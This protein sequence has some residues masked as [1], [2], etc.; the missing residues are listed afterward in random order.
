MA[1]NRLA[2][3]CAVA[4]FTASPLLAQTS[5]FLPDELFEKLVNEISGDRSYENVRHLSLY[6]RTEG[7][8]D[9]FKANEW[10]VSAAKEAGLEDVKLIR[11]KN[12]TPGWTCRKGE[13]WL[14]SGPDAKVETKLAAYGEVA[15]S[16]ADNSRTTH[17]TADL[18][19]VGWGVEESDYK[20]KDVKGKVVF[21]GGPLRKVNAEAVWRR[22]ALGV[23]SY[24]TH[25]P[26][27][28]DAPDQVA[29]T[30]LPYEARDVA[31][32]KDKT[33]PTFA[34]VISPRRA[35]RVQKTLVEGAAKI[36]VDIDAEFQPVPEQALVEGWIRGTENHD[37]QIVLT[38]HTQEG[39]GAN[40]DASG[41]G[42]V[43]EIGRALSRLIKDGKIPR[44]KRDIRFWW[45]NEFGSQER[46]FREDPGQAK[47]MLV[48]LNQDMV[49][50][51]QSLGG[52]VEYGSRLP[53]SIPHVL[54]D[55]MESVLLFM[56]DANTSLL[57][58]RGTKHRQPFT[59]EVVSVKGSREP[60]HARMVPYYDSTDH[61]AF[62]PAHIGVPATSLTNWPDDF[63]H[64]TGDDIDQ[65]DATQ[66]ERN[67]VVTAGVALYF[68]NVSKGDLPLLASY[69]AARGAVRLADD[70][71]TAITLAAGG[72]TTASY[73]AGRGLITNRAARESASLVSVSRL[74]AAPDPALQAILDAGS[75]ALDRAQNT[76]LGRL[77]L[78]AHP[79]GAGAAATKTERALS[80]EE[81][82]LASRIYG[83]GRSVAEIQD[84][85]E[86]MRSDDK[87]PL[88]PMM[89]F[90]VINFADGKRSGLE[91]YD[92]V[93]A[94]AASAGEWYYGKVTAAD[95]KAFLDGAVKAGVCTER[96][97][98]R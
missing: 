91:V 31:G 92:A 16:I 70:A 87:S 47:K 73:Q 78:I 97:A 71:A 59:R 3:V 79:A 64:S 43:L 65:I 52:R 72:K 9:Y 45:V 24:E 57:T 60:Y 10:I 95:V 54:E 98:G 21:A 30:R 27:A 33:P 93:A 41:C 56:R 46:L 83:P 13:A 36:R 2:L 74:A 86:K 94:E 69:A 35:R 40:D 29:W 32:V 51:R 22:G 14:M 58:T 11:Q 20:D 7:S 82:H 38:A 6:H 96:E 66:L 76:H 84:G 15:V 85:L 63:I 12:N 17:L 4:G 5:P 44:P 28:F 53:W 8:A 61:H 39:A 25:R 68:A 67:A 62:T 50:A 80:A 23:L 48:A 26:E 88:H 89:R 75:A 49:G 37:Q 77:D 18:V 34:V 1:L 42:N 90:E 81:K 55:V 19:D